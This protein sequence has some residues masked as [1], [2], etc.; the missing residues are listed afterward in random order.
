MAIKQGIEQLCLIIRHIRS[1]TEQGHLLTITLQWWQ[2]LAGV[3]E[4]LWENPTLPVTYLEPNWLTSVRSFLDQSQSYLHIQDTMTDFPSP[5]R[6]NDQCLM[7]VI[8]QLPLLTTTILKAFHQCRIYMQ[9]TFLSEITTA[10]GL[11]IERTSWIGQGHHNSPLLWPQQQAPGPKSFRIW[12]RLLAS[13]FLL[14]HRRRVCPRTIDLRLQQPLK[15]WLPTSN[16]LRSC[17]TAFFSPTTRQL[18]RATANTYTLHSKTLSPR[19]RGTPQCIAFHLDPH[20]HDHNTLPTDAIPVDPETHPRYYSISRTVPSIQT[21]TTSPPAQSWD[22][23]I[24]QLDTWEQDI[25]QYNQILHTDLLLKLLC[26]KHKVFIASDGGAHDP[27]GS[28]GCLIATKSKILAENG[29]QASGANP[30]SF[31]AEGYGMLSILRLLYRLLQYYDIPQIRGPV[32]MICDSESLIT[33]IKTTINS[34]IC[35]PRRALFSEADVKA[36]ITD[37]LKL[38]KLNIRFQHVHSHPKKHHPNAPLSW[39]K[40]LNTR[41]DEIATQHLDKA[42]TSKPLVPFI[43]ASKAQLQVQGITITHHI[44][45]QIRYLCS[46]QATK[47]YLCHRYSWNAITFDSVDWNLFRS[48]FLAS[49]H[50]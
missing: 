31:R 40:T 45:S 48:S 13:A 43:P 23:Y 7:D 22:A 30:R 18:Y 49:D 44:P 17:W 20:D 35:R 29:G 1:D 28:F 47:Q 14:G 27:L 12:R 21:A 38:L 19:T 11:R 25:L 37:T 2:L 5:T 42:A 15:A 26:S 39:D 24:S 4:P 8:I 36:G 9:V 16:W 46:M 6:T 10:N 50:L 32:R 41:C 3:S 33:R 34:K